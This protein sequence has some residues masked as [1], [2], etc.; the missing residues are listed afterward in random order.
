MSGGAQTAPGFDALTHLDQLLDE[1]PAVCD[2][3]RQAGV[4]GWLVAGWD[5]D[6]W[7]RVREA[8]E[9]SGGVLALGAHPW[10]ADR[11][12]A[13]RA[14]ELLD[15]QDPPVVGEI[16]LD[17]HRSGDNDARARQRALFRA[18]LAW[19]RQRD[20]P[21]VLHAV[22][23]VP[24]VL[25]VL[26]ADGL[27]RAGGM[28]HGLHSGPDLSLRAVQLGLH[29]SVGPLLLG[30]APHRIV[31]SLQRLP[32]QRVLLETDCPEQRIGVRAHPTPADLVYVAGAVARIWGVDPDRVL[33]S[34]GS[35]ARALFRLPVDG[36]PGG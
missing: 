21:V 4:G 32:H 34:T 9:H 3:A 26:A 28:L 10:V 29:V 8:A 25:H 35:A 5:P 1:L 14:T 15:E 17:H 31:A 7:G 33:N 19:A 12:D 27:P 30:R 20:R 36:A 24:E 2:E 22:R 16:G 18:Q 6:G 11:I 13:D 23:A